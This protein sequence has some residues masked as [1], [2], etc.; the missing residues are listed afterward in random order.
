M[1]LIHISTDYVF[2]GN[3]TTPYTEKDNTNPLGVYGKTK[4]E[5]EKKIY[6]SDSR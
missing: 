5:G 1:K 2:N 6:K 3:K 4:L